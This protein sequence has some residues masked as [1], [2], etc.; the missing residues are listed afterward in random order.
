MNGTYAAALGPHSSWMAQPRLLPRLAHALLMAVTMALAACGGGSGSNGNEGKGAPTYTVGG[1]V[2]GLSAGPLVLT[3]GIDRFTLGITT[4]VGVVKDRP[5][6]IASLPTGAA[7]DVRVQTQPVGVSCTVV[8]G[9]NVVATQAVS[10]IQVLCVKRKSLTLV[11]G[12]APHYGGLDGAGTDAGFNALRSAAVDTAGNIYTIDQNAIRKITPSG[13][14]STLAGLASVTGS[15]DGAG[16]NARFANPTDL[17]VA[18]DGQVF[19]AD[20][21]NDSVRVVSPT[22]VVSTL[23]INATQKA[24]MLAT[25]TGGSAC[26]VCGPIGRDGAGNLYLASGSSHTAITRLSPSGNLTLWAGTLSTGVTGSFYA[27]NMAVDEAGNIYLAGANA[28]GNNLVKFDT[29]AQPT[30]ITTFSNHVGGMARASDGTIWFNTNNSQGTVRTVYQ[31]TPDGTVATHP[32]PSG[33]SRGGGWLGD[34]AALPGGRLY[35]VDTDVNGL[36]AS[37][38]GQTPAVFAGYGRTEDNING[39]GSVARFSQPG[40]IAMRADGS[41]VMSDDGNNAVRR[42]SS[43]NQVSTMWGRTDF[44]PNQL[45]ITV[46]GVAVDGA[47]HS[48]LCQSG[49]GVSRIEPDG[50]VTPFAT[51]CNRASF[52]TASDGLLT[53]TSDCIYKYSSAGVRQTVACKV[54]SP[55]DASR[56][57]LA[58]DSIAPLPNGQF[59][60]RDGLNLKLVSA[61]GAVS[62]LR[63]VTEAFTLF[64]D[65]RGNVGAITS[66]GID[67][68]Y[69]TNYA[70]AARIVDISSRTEV[71]PLPTTIQA[72]TSAAFRNDQIILVIGSTL[73]SVDL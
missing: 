67:L 15:A 13:I 26:V 14:V 63:S 33:Q 57:L 39:D 29:N 70:S 51:G 12:A 25:Q 37:D 9:S 21:G 59:L 66:T 8:H 61:S 41:V 34:M 31:V 23:A 55:P 72:P 28:V 36:L 60:V 40:A 48:F 20:Q 53:T 64:G 2:A 6:V 24:A 69:G 18:P 68:L 3:N 49:G 47:Q 5:F 43:D 65:G 42:I 54:A 17:T 22:G 30:T 1:T 19:V 73:F 56:A 45:S 44:N 32:F 62:T 4:D 7:Y 35:V 11:A 10:D 38:G 71:G 46:R 16:A 50:S 58:I 52:F 27:D